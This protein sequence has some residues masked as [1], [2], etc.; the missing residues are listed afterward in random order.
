MQDIKGESDTKDIP[1]KIGAI[2]NSKYP[3]LDRLN[4]PSK[5]RVGLKNKL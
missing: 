3:K 5:T 1:Q 4:I 2:S